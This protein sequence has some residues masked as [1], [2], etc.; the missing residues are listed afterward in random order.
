MTKTSKKESRLRVTL[1]RTLSIASVL[2]L[3]WT[4]DTV[5]FVIL[6]LG[7]LIYYAPTTAAAPCEP[8]KWIR[9]TWIIAG[10][11]V[12][13]VYFATNIE[14]PTGSIVPPVLGYGALLLLAVQIL[15][16]VVRNRMLASTARE[17]QTSEQAGDGDAEEAV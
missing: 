3:Y 11:S 4:P 16:D 1:S 2:L 14:P 13:G 9:A 12:C 17:S 15:W 10:L 8:P 5:A 7:T 6:G